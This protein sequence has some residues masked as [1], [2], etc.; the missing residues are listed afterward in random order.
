V[1]AAVERLEPLAAD[2]TAGEVVLCHDISL[3]LYHGAKER[4]ALFHPEYYITTDK[5]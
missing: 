4:A 2:R 5:P 3:E 1:V